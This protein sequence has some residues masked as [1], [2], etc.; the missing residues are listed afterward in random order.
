[1][2][3]IPRSVPPP[4]QNFLLGPEPH[5]DRTPG[6]WTLLSSSGY[7]VDKGSKGYSPVS[8]RVGLTKRKKGP[9]TV[10]TGD[11]KG[12]VVDIVSIGTGEDGEDRRPHTRRGGQTPFYP[13]CKTFYKNLP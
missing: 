4:Q 3:T 1:M 5:V 12:Q 10:H 6:S 13:L 9:D 7:L 2:T 11:V 8:G